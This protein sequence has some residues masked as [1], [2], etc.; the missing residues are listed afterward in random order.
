MRTR[1]RKRGSRACGTPD[2]NLPKS[3]ENWRGRELRRGGT[4]KPPCQDQLG[5]RGRRNHK[6]QQIGK[7]SRPYFVTKTQGQKKEEKKYNYPNWT[8]CHSEKASKKR[9]GVRAVGAA[10]GAQ[11]I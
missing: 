4:Q 8:D 1:K 10:G 3:Q 7:S 5:R 9:G 2:N 11:H 6:R